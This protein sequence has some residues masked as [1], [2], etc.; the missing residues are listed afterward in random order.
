MAKKQ[1]DENVLVDCKLCAYGSDEVVNYLI[2][3]NNKVCNPKGYK[4]GD[5]KRECRYYQKRK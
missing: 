2:A 5:W 1:T 4:M 3:C